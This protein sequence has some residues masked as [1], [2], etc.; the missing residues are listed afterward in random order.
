MLPLS[1]GKANKSFI[2]SE[3]A[4]KMGGIKK[5]RRVYLLQEIL[6]KPYCLRVTY[7]SS[8]ENELECRNSIQSMINLKAYLAQAER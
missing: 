3:E 8:A 6:N 1:Q 5:T 2:V 4:I 7:F